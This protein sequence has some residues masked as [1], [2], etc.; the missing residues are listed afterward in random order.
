VDAVTGAGTPRLID[1]I[2]CAIRT[3]GF[4]PRTER[5][6]VHWVRRFVRFH[7]RVHPTEVGPAGIGPFLSYLAAERHVSP[8]T[9]NQALAALLFLYIDVLGHPASVQRHFVRARRPQR[10]PVVLSLAE[11]AALFAHLRGMPWLM[12]SFLYG[13]GLRV[14]E[15][16]SLR[17]KD[18]D[19]DRR[20]IR[21]RA[22]KGNKD[23]VALF[24][25]T[26]V[27]PLRRHLHWVRGVH[28]ADC[29]EGAGYV[30]L[31]TALARKY[32]N[33]AREWAWQWIFPATRTYR[34]PL[35]GQTR[36]HHFHETA[37]QR[38]VRFAAVAAGIP[39]PVSCHT[40]RHSFA[41]HLLESG[42]DIRTIQELLGHR[43]LATTMLYTHVLNRG[44]LGVVSPFDNL[45]SPPASR[46][47]AHEL[48][49]YTDPENDDEKE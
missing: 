49:R 48:P 10:I 44:P 45:K 11:V 27:R 25:A 26:L 33:A 32:P 36:R 31:P 23:R 47:R 35:T 42:H 22:A 24:P 1:Q 29:H 4:S 8:S 3:R 14:S 21:I 37:L 18:I 19:F 16:A 20:E 17:V 34:D 12:A 46:Q 28:Q 7:G 15:C 13:S 6:Y 41:T 30:A 40:L 43:D 5:A 9:Q 2:R 39:K 38:A